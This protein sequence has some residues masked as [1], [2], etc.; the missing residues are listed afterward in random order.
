MSATSTPSLRPYLATTGRILRQLRND[1]RTVAMILVVPALL[2]ALLYFIYQ[3]TPHPPGQPSLFD[4]VGISMLGILPFIVMFLITAIAM[5]RERTSGTL[6]RLLTTPLTKGDLL[7]GYGTAF[8]LAAAA[9]AIVA[10]LVAFGPLD[11]QAAGDPLWVVVIAVVD[12]ICGVALGLLASAFA[13]TEFQAVQFMPLVV[14]P[15]IFL[16]GLLVPRDQLPGWLQPVSD[17]LPLS[18]AVDALQEVSRNPEVTGQ[19]WRDIG[20]VAAFAVVAL[21][22]G[23]A[24]L[25]R[26]TA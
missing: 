19:M 22:L 20:V 1:R 10:C 26:R 4:R 23:A 21:A 12:A 25:R 5:Q 18:Y 8:S 3:D 14:A 17:V 16:C 2:M 24:T 13:R 11:L 6:E 15:Q 7:A 9:Q